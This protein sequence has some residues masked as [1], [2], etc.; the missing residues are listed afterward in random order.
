MCVCVCVCVC[1]GVDDLGVGFTSVCFVM[2][3]TVVC[4]LKYWCVCLKVSVRYY[5]ACI[6]E[7]SSSSAGAECLGDFLKKLLFLLTT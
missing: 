3:A 5:R 7:T 6:G 4:M 2:N 1:S